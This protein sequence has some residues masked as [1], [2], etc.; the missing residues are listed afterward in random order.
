M[1]HTILKNTAILT[2]GGLVLKAI[3]F[4]FNV[5]VVR[6]LGGD[7]Y[8]SY[9]IVASFVGLFGIF[10]EWGASQF[11]SRE[12][13]RHRSHVPKLFVNLIAVRLLLALVGVIAIPL[14][15]AAFG[16]GSSVVLG[17]LFYTFTF[18]LA[19]FDAPL[20]TLLTAHE[21]F[22]AVTAMTL[23]GQV[24]FAAFGF[25]ALISG[26]GF[27]G[28]VAVGVL[29]MLPRIV[30]GTWLARQLGILPT[31]HSIAHIAPRSWPALLRGGLPFGIIALAL[32]VAFNIDSVMLSHFQPERVV[33]WYA[34]SYGLVFT[35]VALLGG[36]TQAM[37]PSLAQ[38]YTHDAEKVKT[39]Y[40]HSVKAI[41]LTT[42]PMAVGGMLL[43][44]SIITLLYGQAM[45]PAAPA[46]A[47]LIWDLPLLMFASFCGNMTTVVGEERA[48]ARIYVI[49][50]FANVA[51][52]LIV[53]PRFGM[54]GAAVVTVATDF[55]TTAQFYA[56][57]R[58]KL[59]LPSMTSAITRIVLASALMGIVVAAIAL[60]QVHVLV[61]IVVGAMT[62]TALAV[63]L[64]LLSDEERALLQRLTG[65]IAGRLRLS[66]S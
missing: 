62:Y 14:A 32:S 21:R 64:R 59:D 46:F 20:E 52:N 65:S 28:L 50:A 41:A 60:L 47:I 40:R 15:G 12:I 33:G 25:I 58:R 13:A 11:V 16:Y 29:S 2:L 37:V 5:Y 18:V 19:A 31:L 49:G 56:L 17:I 6:L 27:I 44:S 38:A 35:L 55:V 48:A 3:N 43:A 61:L 24:A 42:V 63:I 30:L 26:G 39:W 51:L 23:V 9:M 57:L 22:D 8:G 66:R 7:A 54:L 36:V 34:L 45:S 1:G 53:I 4:L 10:V